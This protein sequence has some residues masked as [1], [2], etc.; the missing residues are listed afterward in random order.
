ME[1]ESLLHSLLLGVSVKLLPETSRSFNTVL[2]TCDDPF[3]RNADEDVRLGFYDGKPAERSYRVPSG[4]P[5]ILPSHPLLEHRLFNLW[6]G[7]DGWGTQYAVSR[8]FSKLG[9]LQNKFKYKWNWFPNVLSK[10]QMFYIY[11]IILVLSPCKILQQGI[12][13]NAVAF[14]AAILDRCICFISGDFFFFLAGY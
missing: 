11:Y 12:L 8:M 14:W 4:I 5:N 13:F 2:R 1:P 7:V 3:C 10:M 6:P 9:T